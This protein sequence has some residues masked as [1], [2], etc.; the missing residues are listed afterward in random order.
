MI[1]VAFQITFRI[2]IYVND[3]FLFFKN[4]F[5]HYYIKTIQNIQIVLNFN[6]KKIKFYEK[7]FQPRFQTLPEK[8]ATDTHSRSFP[9]RL[10]Y[11]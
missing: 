9:G 8:K 1:A 11:L 5:W 6:K 7:Q 4:Y 2:K 10:Y 3:V